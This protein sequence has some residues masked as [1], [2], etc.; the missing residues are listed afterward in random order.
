MRPQGLGCFLCLTLLTPRIKIDHLVAWRH[1]RD[2]LVRLPF[3][4]SNGTDQ[5]DNKMFKTTAARHVRV[6]SR[7]H[8]IRSGQLHKRR[9]QQS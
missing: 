8:G 9:K 2:E 5:E 4:G 7:R 6:R 3:D 1:G